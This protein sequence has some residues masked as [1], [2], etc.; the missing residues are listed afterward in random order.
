M[1]KTNKEFS[2]RS[3]SCRKLTE[4]LFQTMILKRKH[5]NKIRDNLNIRLR[6]WK[7]KMLSA[8]RSLLLTLYIWWMGNKLTHYLIIWNL[9]TPVWSLSRVQS[10]QL[11]D[12]WDIIQ[13]SKK[14][15]L[16]GIQSTKFSLKT[17]FTLTKRCL[18]CK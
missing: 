16:E 6:F 14:N 3:R 5:L 10:K 2:F 4:Y 12:I 15:N 13:Q 8:L 11:S 7:R 18:I 9:S 17:K 1:E